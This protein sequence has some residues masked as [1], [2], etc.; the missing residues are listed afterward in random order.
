MGK[1]ILGYALSAFCNQFV[2]ILLIIKIRSSAAFLRPRYSAQI[3]VCIAGEGKANF[4][5][6]Y[7]NTQK[8]IAH[9]Q[10][11]CGRVPVFADCFRNRIPTGLADCNGTTGR[12]ADRGASVIGECAKQLCAPCFFTAVGI[13]YVF[14]AAGPGGG[15]SGV[16]DMK[17]YH[18]IASIIKADDCIARRDC[19]ERIAGEGS[20][21]KEKSE[22]NSN[23]SFHVFT[24]K[25]E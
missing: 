9:N 5:F 10:I 8:L 15:S 1:S 17:V 7:S 16:K 12:G 20:G 13:V 2:Y 25:D 22:N 23:Q 14:F 19:G 11:G 18:N 4:A 21:S 3:A 24:P 6:K